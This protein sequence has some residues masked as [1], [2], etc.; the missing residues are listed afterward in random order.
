MKTIRDIA[1]GVLATALLLLLVLDAGA[2]TGNG[3]PVWMW[4]Q[5]RVSETTNA[6]TLLFVSPLPEAAPK[7]LFVSPLFSPVFSFAPE[8][9]PVP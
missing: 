9:T 5:P 1:V 7:L 8:T 6:P 2:A 3:S 4:E